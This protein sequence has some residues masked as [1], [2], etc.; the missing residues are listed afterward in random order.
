MGG[1][2]IRD[3]VTSRLVVQNHAEEATMDRQSAV[4]AAVID[5]TQLP[6]LVHEMTDP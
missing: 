5:K 4:G 1:S 6:E 3:G 2:K